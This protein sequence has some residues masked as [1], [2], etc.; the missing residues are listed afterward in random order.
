LIQFGIRYYDPT[1]GRWTQQDPLGG[2]LFDPSTGNR[3]AYANANPVN[4]VDP[5]GADIGRAV[6]SCVYYADVLGISGL[7]AGATI[8][9][10][11]G[12]VNPAGGPIGGALLGGLTGLGEGLIGGCLYGFITTIAP[13]LF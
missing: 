10:I 9:A 6:K 5:T 3:Y 12:F 7:I 11:A 8:G 4:L 2:S 13:P 1:L